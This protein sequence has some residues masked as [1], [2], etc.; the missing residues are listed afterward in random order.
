[1]TKFKFINSSKDEK[2]R[3]KDTVEIT[4]T[5]MIIFEFK[6]LL[7]NAEMLLTLMN[8]MIMKIKWD[9][10]CL[11]CWNSSSMSENA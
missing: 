11:S 7:I 8:E 9:W 1:M 5:E 6:K 2:E 10:W 4:V 3:D